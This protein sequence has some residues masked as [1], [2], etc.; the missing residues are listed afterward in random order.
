MGD[1]REKLNRQDTERAKPDFDDEI[2]S[3]LG[4]LWRLGG[5]TSRQ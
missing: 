4:G 2:R 5:S 1:D 3:G